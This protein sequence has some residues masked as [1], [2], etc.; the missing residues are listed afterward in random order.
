MLKAGGLLGRDLRVSFKKYSKS[1]TSGSLDLSRFVDE[2]TIR[3]V[4][5][6]PLAQVHNIFRQLGVK[7]VLVA[8]FGSLAGLITKK[9]FVDHL[10]EGHIGHVAKDPVVQRRSMFRK[11]VL[12]PTDEHFEENRTENAEQREQPRLPSNAVQGGTK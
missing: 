11:P 1:R 10:H 7:L 8:R 6:T 9:S 12:H 5:E 2:T 3:L 4:P